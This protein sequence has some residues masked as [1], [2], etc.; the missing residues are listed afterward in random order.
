MPGS[1]CTKFNVLVWTDDK[2]GYIILVPILCEAKKRNYFQKCKEEKEK[3]K[4]KRGMPGSICTKFNVLVWTDDKAG[5][6]V[7]LLPIV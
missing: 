5:Y 6:I 4:F 3:G 7:L 1:I 2:A